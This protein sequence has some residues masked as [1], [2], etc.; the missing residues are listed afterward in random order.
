M[1][2][3][4]KGEGEGDRRKKIKRNEMREG[5]KERKKNKEG[6]K[7]RREIERKGI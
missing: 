6:S 7:G 1:V 3:A 2:D 5:D 4:K